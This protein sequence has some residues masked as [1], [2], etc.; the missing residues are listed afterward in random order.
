[1]LFWQP[2]MQGRR[3]QQRLVHVC[4]SKTLSHGRILSPNTLWKSCY[5]WCFCRIYSRQT[6]RDSYLSRSQCTAPRA[7]VKITKVHVHVCIFL[8]QQ[9]CLKSQMARKSSIRPLHL[10][11]HVAR[12]FFDLFR[13]PNH[14]DRQRVLIRL[15]HV[16]F[17]L[18]GQLQQ[19]VGVLLEVL[20]P[21]F[22]RDL[23]RRSFLLGL[24]FDFCG[25]TLAL[26]RNRWHSLV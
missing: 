7:A 6:P 26:A 9:D 18:G 1:M 13:L 8:G 23:F 14:V 10:L 11:F 24:P 5:V 12:Q 4:G 15:V 20:L 16:L 22:I 2:I 17:Q 19:F 21:F 3:E 25:G